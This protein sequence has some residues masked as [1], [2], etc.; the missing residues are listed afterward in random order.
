MP[1]I[2]F[3]YIYFIVVNLLLFH[4][5]LD[6]P[7]EVAYRF[8]L[9]GDWPYRP[10]A[11]SDYYQG[12]ASSASM[13][14]LSAKDETIRRVLE[15]TQPDTV[16]DVGCNVG[17]YAV[18]A[19]TEG[20]RV[21]ACD[22]DET[23]IAQ[24]YHQ[25]QDQGLDILPLVIDVANPT[26]AFGWGGRQYS[27]AIDRFRVD[28]VFASALVHHL[29]IHQY[30]DFERVVGTL[31]PFTKRWL[32]VEFVAPD[33]PKSRTMLERSL[34]D[35]SWYDLKSF[36]ETLQRHFNKVEALEPYSESRTLLLCE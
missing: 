26:P 13:P 10:T 23:C 4:L 7:R 9:Y 15:A 5:L 29:I 28:M 24:L 17:R 12:S 2:R 8:K 16:F 1:R 35:F 27:S 34:R 33:D 19:A 32:L 18:M 30:H 11:W 22:K 25:S 20:A 14:D 36:M 31:K 21:V 6:L 3:P